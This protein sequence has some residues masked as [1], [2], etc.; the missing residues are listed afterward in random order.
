[1]NH[2]DVRHTVYGNDW[3]RSMNDA[4]RDVLKHAQTRFECLAEDFTKAGED[5]D[6]AMCETDAELMAAALSA[7]AC[8]PDGTDVDAAAK[9]LCET[10]LGI[11]WDGLRADGRARDGG[12]PPFYRGFC[13][14]RQDDV[15]DVVSEII[16]LSCLDMEQIGWQSRKLSHPSVGWTNWFDIS[17][18][19]AQYWQQRIA[20]GEKSIELRGVYAFAAKHPSPTRTGDNRR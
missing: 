4:L 10:V 11:L 1:M 5:V 2:L 15:R 20:N 3:T 13:N 9:Y 16:R 7:L 6:R 17:V 18:S 14:A 8:I 19:E 12:F